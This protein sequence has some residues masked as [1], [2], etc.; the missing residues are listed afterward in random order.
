MARVLTRQSH[1]LQGLAE[2]GAHEPRKRG[3]WH[4]FGATARVFVAL[5]QSDVPWSAF[6][7]SPPPGRSGLRR[8]YLRASDFQTVAQKSASCEPVFRPRTQYQN[9]IE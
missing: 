2:I 9:C 5:F 6:C 8:T 7:G 3:L 4:E 1:V